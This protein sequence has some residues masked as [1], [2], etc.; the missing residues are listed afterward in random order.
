MATKKKDLP[1]ADLDYATGLGLLKGEWEKIVELLGRTPN[2]IECCIFSAVWS[3]SNSNKSAIRYLKSLPGAKEAKFE[4][5]IRHLG[6]LSIDDS[7]SLVFSVSHNNKLTYLEPRSGASICIARTLES[8]A[9]TGAFPIASLN[10]LR[11]GEF[12]EIDSQRHFR[13]TVSSIASFSN[14]SGLP[15]VGGELLFNANYNGAMVINNFAFGV[16]NSKLLVES[17]QIEPKTAIFYIGS[18]TAED[19]LR[20]DIPISSDPYNTHVTAYALRE[21]VNKG[22]LAYLLNIAESGLASSLV[23]LS[24]LTKSGIRIDLERVP[25]VGDQLQPQDILLSSSLNRYICVATSSEH[26]ALTDLLSEFGCKATLIGEVVDSE[27]IELFWHHHEVGVIPYQLIFSNLIEKQYATSK[28][29][30]KGQSSRDKY[31]KPTSK[32]A[33]KQKIKVDEWDMLRSVPKT[34][35]SSQEK[36]KC[37]LEFKLPSNL[38]DVWIDLLADPNISSKHA[39]YKNYDQTLYGNTFVHAGGDASVIR[40]KSFNEKSERAVA[41]SVDSNTLFIKGDPYFG[42][43]HTVAEGLRNISAVGAVPKALLSCFNYGDINRD[44]DFY[45]FTESIHGLADAATKLGLPVLSDSVSLYNINDAAIGFSIPSILMIGI[46]EDLRKACPNWFVKENDRILLLGNT[47]NE[48]GWS[49]YLNY[50]HQISDGEIPKLDLDLEKKTCEIIRDFINQDL[51]ESAHD[52]SLGG[53]AI[54]I[55][56]CALS[57]PSPLG[58][59]LSIN[60]TLPLQAEREDVLLFSESASRFLVS[61]KKENEATLRGKCKE[62]GIQVT[63]EGEVGGETISI[64]GAVNCSIPLS[65]ANKIWTNGLENS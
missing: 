36:A 14:T 59:T 57:G 8:I 35:E 24:Q 42:T 27:D 44:R 1:L 31:D 55:T 58:A 33:K 46:I 51:L 12:D 54:A 19:G 2:Q 60:Q 18:P 53:L 30:S 7:T 62:V 45:M 52:L 21:A 41:L 32:S 40:V 9:S 49:E 56:E 28:L 34:Q 37:K 10:L 15:V 47:Y 63:G 50:Y 17:K 25:I 64:Q 4:K 11:F 20:K 6:S 48:V 39:V 22:M 16:V 23:E 29:S 5:R 3:E 38:D 65:T 61:C 13:D 26:R 43:L